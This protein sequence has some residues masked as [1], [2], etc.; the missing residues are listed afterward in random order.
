MDASAPRRY[1]AHC[2]TRLASDNKAAACGPCQRAAAEAELSPPQVPPE[3][4]DNDQLRDALVRERHI[5]HAVRSYRK[6][7]HHGHREISQE[8]AARWLSVSQTQLSRIERGRP[9]YDL[10]RLIQW[11]KK[12]QIPPELLWFS[13]PGEGE[14]DV[15]RRKFL[16][17]SGTT[18]VIGGIAPAS[19]APDLG[20]PQ[21][22]DSEECAQWLAWELWNRRTATLNAEEIPP[23]LRRSLAALPPA[24]TL[25]L[26]DAHDNYSFAHP[27]LVDF[28]V[29]Q[30]IFGDLAQGKS[31]LL[32]TTQTSHDTDQ[33]IRRFVQHDN[34]C[35]PI[36]S[37]WMHNGNT[38]VLRVNSAGILAKLG[39]ADIADQVIAVLRQDTDTRNLY[40]TA[41]ASRVLS[42][43][44]EQAGSL[45]FGNSQL[46]SQSAMSSDQAAEYSVQLSQE[47]RNSQDGAARWCSVVL[48]SRIAQPVPN[49]VTNALQETLRGEQCRENLRAIASA[50]SNADPLQT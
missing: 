34:A 20:N 47:V 46:T 28:F 27:S 45:A 3:F 36:L 32:T 12:L 43:P 39:E 5:G 8:A 26:R 7:P 35:V 19:I 33:V 29:A 11:A 14:E 24:G 9:V 2:G 48:L 10:D 16:M 15:N 50:L 42:L 6:H 17:A 31:G 22:M 13:L 23:N 4:W 49:L 30:R 44:W 37:Q 18:A 1:C 21:I 40:L 38:P 25:I 41:V